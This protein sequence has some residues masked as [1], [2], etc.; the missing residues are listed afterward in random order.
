MIGANKTFY[1][2]S[3]IFT[4]GL[5]VLFSL[6]SK[7]APLALNH[8]IYFCQKVLSN[9]LFTLPHSFPS[10][11]V[12]I[13]LLVVFVGF[14]LLLSKFVK[15]QLFIKRVLKNKIATP[16]KIY[17]IASRLN[18]KKDIDVVND[19]RFSSFCYGFVKPRICLSLNLTQSLSE[20][21][22]T[23][24][25]LHES[26]HLKHK[27]P[28]K[29]ILS[30]VAASMFFFVPTLKDFQSHYVLSKEVAADQLA[31]QDRGSWGIRTALIKVLNF[32]TPSFSGVSSFANE[33]SLEKRVEILTNPR[34]GLRIKISGMRLILSLVVFLSALALL[35]LPVYAVENGDSHAYFI[36]PYGD[37]CM[38]TCSMGGAAKELPFSTQKQFTPANHSPNN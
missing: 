26:Y 24:V 19:Q 22:L 3:T 17:K 35:N 34:S 28:L 10:L 30:E 7:V 25:I 31:V 9:I 8:T 13:L 16:K 12:L 23:A 2:L 32:S 21:E 29:I 18:I 33:D 4:V 36:C 14:S 1:I 20:K 15:T 27:D 5:F 6:L 11:L 38:M 37:E